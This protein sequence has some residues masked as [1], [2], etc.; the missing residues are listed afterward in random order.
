[1]VF[2]HGTFDELGCGVEVHGLCQ[3]SRGKDCLW[4]IG[5]KIQ[6][7]VGKQQPSSQYMS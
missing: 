1:M 3:K 5:D 4:L 7:T 2:P 6:L